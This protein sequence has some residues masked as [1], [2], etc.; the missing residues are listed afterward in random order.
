MSLLIF[1]GLLASGIIAAA[2]KLLG[3]DH[4]TLG[5]EAV[6]RRGT[7]VAQPCG[8]EAARH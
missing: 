2:P 7:R 5:D 6:N 4:G 8:A 1:V 3:L